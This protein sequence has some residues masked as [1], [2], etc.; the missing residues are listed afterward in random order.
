MKRVFVDTSGFVAALVAEDRFQERA[1][2][3]FQQGAREGWELVTTNAIVFE[4]YTVLRKRAR[5]GRGAALRFLDVIEQGLC[6][7][8][9]IEPDDETR[10][11]AI[12][13]EHDDK[14]YSFCDALSFA[15]MERLALTDGIAF[16]RDFRSYGHFTLL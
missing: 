10:A 5:D 15:V 13:R 12:L 16:D 3:L 1:A 11:I 14:A 8:A 7:V 9:R 4:T 2:A 6:T